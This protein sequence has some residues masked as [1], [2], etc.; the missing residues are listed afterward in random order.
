MTKNNSLNNNVQK[1]K[2]IFLYIIDIVLYLTL[3]ILFF[4]IFWIIYLSV[5]FDKYL[6]IEMNETTN[7]KFWVWFIQVYLLICLIISPYLIYLNHKILKNYH[8]NYVIE[9]K[10]IRHNIF[11]SIPMLWIGFIN[12]ILYLLLSGIKNLKK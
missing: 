9:W 7:S 6:F 4:D 12:I 11:L 8:K 10:K 1:E 5:A 3:C 2:I